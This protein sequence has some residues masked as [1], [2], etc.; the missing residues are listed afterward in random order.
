VS[1]AQEK[2]AVKTLEDWNRL[3][4]RTE[5]GSVEIPWMSLQYESALGDNPHQ[6]R[7]EVE[8]L[9][10]RLGPGARTVQQNTT[11]DNGGDGIGLFGASHNTVQRNTSRRNGIDGI[12]ANSLSVGNVFDGNV[13]TGN[14]NYD[15]ADYSIGLGTAGTANDWSGN[16]GGTDNQNGLLLQYQYSVP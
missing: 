6:A 4:G 16:A 11:D 2:R 3:W 13:M 15:A 7:Q 1:F 12:V 10:R 8:R 9:C 5:P 14:R